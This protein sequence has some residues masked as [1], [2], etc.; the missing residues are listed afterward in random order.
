MA[1]KLQTNGHRRTTR[2][3]IPVFDRD[4]WPV[5]RM[6]L[7]AY[8]DELNSDCIDILTG[9]L[10][11]PGEEFDAEELQQEMLAN[12]LENDPDADPSKVMKK[13]RA[14]I[15][16]LRTEHP[17]TLAKYLKAN[18][19]IHSTLVLSLQGEDFDLVGDCCS[20]ADRDGLALWETIKQEY[21]SGTDSNILAVICQVIAN[22]QKLGQTLS[23]Y[24]YKLGILLNQ[25]EVMDSDSAFSEK[26][27]ICMFLQGLQSKYKT[28]VDII[29]A[30]D[31]S[32]YSEC[33]KSVKDYADREGIK[34]DTNAHIVAQKKCGHCGKQG[35]VESKCWQ[36]HPEARP[37][38]ASYGRPR[39][40]KG[41]KPTR[42]GRCYKCGKA[43]HYQHECLEKDKEPDTNATHLGVGG[44]KNTQS[45]ISG[46]EVVGGHA[47][48]CMCH[49]QDFV[50]G[51]LVGGRKQ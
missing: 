35:H 8:F 50:Q 11:H 4:N 14:G 37:N 42:K 43:G 19:K 38:R 2:I 22:R 9:V 16:V 32:S 3:S 15:E 24:K 23:Q 13:H 10:E 34:N 6:K 49:G 20:S 26:M 48:V 36:L 25:L 12:A 40:S 18:R 31:L 44:K 47:F 51:R 5:S 41:S 39:N 45:S 1:S 17:E 7:F 28:I 27:K 46:G 21:E 33:F 29:M 30:K